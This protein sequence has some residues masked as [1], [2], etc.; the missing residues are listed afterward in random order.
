MQ[1]SVKAQCQ[2]VLRMHYIYFFLYA[3]AISM[4]THA[5]GNEMVGVGRKLIIVYPFS[6]YHVS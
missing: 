3:S 2:T 1:S 4:N 6:F 5:T